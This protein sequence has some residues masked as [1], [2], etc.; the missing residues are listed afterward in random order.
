[1]ADITQDRPTGLPAG[2]PDERG[3]PAAEV[4]ASRRT[5]LLMGAGG[6]AVA[7]GL[8]GDVYAVQRGVFAAGTGDAYE[9][10]RTWDRSAATPLGL[11]QAGILAAN[12]HNAQ[13]WRFGIS[14]NRVD[15]YDDTRRSLGT[16]DAY[17]R[18]VQ[19]SAGCAVENISLAA[20]A[21]GVTPT[22]VLTPTADPALLARIE[23]TPGATVTSPLY[24]AIPSRHT[25]R[26][27][28]QRGRNL[29]TGVTAAAAALGA[30]PSVRILWLLS[31]EQKAA[32]STL[33]VTATEA[34]IADVSSR[35]TTT[36][37]TAR[38]GSSSSRAA[39]A[40]PSTPAASRPC[41]G[42]SARSSRPAAP[43]T[44]ATGSPAPGTASC[45]PRRRSGSCWSATP[46]TS[47]TGS[48]PA[49]STSGCTCGP[50]P[51]GWRCSR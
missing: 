17:R 42:H 9:P 46:P 41:S 27:P 36:T 51:R 5:V 48:T 50:S 13:A 30:E 3:R 29:P 31:P 4:Q 37:G 22:V 25:D 43:R 7:A 10:W 20:Q 2:S 19:L 1:M 16:V 12:A 47:R 23:L 11:V 26:A 24:R 39:T 28:Y 32:F 35:A 8:A 44:A 38:P 21:A 14:E 45:P 40:S 15:V 34:F 33:T 49:G 18:E 6:L